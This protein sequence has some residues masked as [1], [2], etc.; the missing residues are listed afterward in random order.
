MN[1]IGL[2][3]Y[4]LQWFYVYRA[5]TS[6]A[7][8]ATKEGFG[9][10]KFTVGGGLS[11]FPVGYL[12]KTKTKNHEDL[13]PCISLLLILKTGYHRNLKL[14]HGMQRQISPQILENSRDAS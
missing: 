12:I 9:S 1:L 3:Y 4:L 6:T 8:V 11:C 7:E 13:S 5:G 10:P 2:D 14:H